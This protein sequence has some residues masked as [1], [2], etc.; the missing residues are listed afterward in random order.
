MDFSAPTVKV[1]NSGFEAPVRLYGAVGRVSSGA[2]R[3]V[4]NDL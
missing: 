1:F 4:S 2:E 3:R